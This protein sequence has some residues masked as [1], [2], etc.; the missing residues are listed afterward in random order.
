[1]VRSRRQLGPRL[2]R[3]AVNILCFGCR[4]QF[5]FFVAQTHLWQIITGIR[6][7]LLLTFWFSRSFP[8][9]YWQRDR[10]IARTSLCCITGHGIAGAEH[11]I[12]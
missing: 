6:K 2:R 1:M 3:V 10:E 7:V 12:T 4:A 9:L 11:A 8:G 5:P